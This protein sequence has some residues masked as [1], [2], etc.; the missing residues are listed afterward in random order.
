[1]QRQRYMIV[2]YSLATEKALGLDAQGFLVNHMHLHELL[3]TYHWSR[4]D[5]DHVIVLG[6]YSISKQK[7]LDNHPAV[8]ILP[9]LASTK[10]LHKV[11][12]KPAHWLALKSSLSLDDP[13]T[14]SD[15]VDV[16]HT[17]HGPIYAPLN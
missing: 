16:L 2:E 10:H 6:N 5:N 8:T 17:I 4:L 11:S 7:E 15:V 9:H 12:K 13:S 3:A 1:M 14:M